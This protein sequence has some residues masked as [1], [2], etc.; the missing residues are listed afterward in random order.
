MF[1]FI[2]CFLFFISFFLF[3]GFYFF[4]FFVDYINTGF[5]K[6]FSV[7]HIIFKLMVVTLHII[8]IIFTG[9]DLL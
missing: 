2:I 8:Y 4:F 6:I 1:H 5:K 3:L 9:I 7:S